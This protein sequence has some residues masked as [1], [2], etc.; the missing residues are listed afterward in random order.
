MENRSSG[1][2]GAFVYLMGLLGIRCASIFVVLTPSLPPSRPGGRLTRQRREDNG[3]QGFI[4]KLLSASL[5]LLPVF[6]DSSVKL[7][8]ATG[9]QLTGPVAAFFVLIGA[10][11]FIYYPEK[12][13]VAYEK[14]SIGA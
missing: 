8:P 9:I 3:A 4:S 14:R 1:W 11:I 2:P 5:P 12:E 10:I 6:C 7:R 13:V